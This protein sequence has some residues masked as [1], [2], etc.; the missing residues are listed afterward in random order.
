VGISLTLAFATVVLLHSGALALNPGQQAQDPRFERAQELFNA[1]TTVRGNAE[2]ACQLMKEL[3][4][5]QPGDKTYSKFQRSYCQQVDLMLNAER[6]VYDEGA[7]AAQSGACDKAQSNLEQM[8]KSV[9][10]TN[11]QYRDRLKQAVAD[12]KRGAAEKKRTEEEAKK[13]KQMQEEEEKWGRCVESEQAGKYSD[14]R[15]CLDQISRGG[16]SKADQARL[17]LALLDMLEKEEKAYEE[18]LRLYNGHDY[19]SARDRFRAVK[20]IRG[21]HE[22]EA[23]RYLAQIDQAEKNS[24]TDYFLRSG[25]RAYL[26]SDFT[27]AE[28]YLSEYLS[29]GGEKQWMAYFFL[30]A[31]HSSQYFLSPDRNEQEM[32]QAADGFREAKSREKQTSRKDEI[33]RV[34][35]VV[36]PRI[37]ELYA[38]SQ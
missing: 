18:G 22:A 2:Q 21:K 15:S 19:R 13:Q 25:L 3:V 34:Q 37:W 16:G 11:P 26:D 4:K 12:C 23:N 5:E 10:T 20:E 30:G 35:A 28:R 8:I 29:K 1:A 31:A 38:K 27:Q 32:R 36:S 9:L 33:S 17:H 24:A 14:A 7:Q 6:T